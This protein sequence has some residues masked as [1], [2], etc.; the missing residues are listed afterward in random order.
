MCI[1]DR[2]R[3][4]LTRNTMSFSL[5]ALAGIALGINATGAIATGFTAVTHGRALPVIDH[6][7]IVSHDGARVPRARR[8]PRRYRISLAAATIGPRAAPTGLRSRP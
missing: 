6:A 4:K 3:D 2:Q 5:V 7:I 1:R 8:S